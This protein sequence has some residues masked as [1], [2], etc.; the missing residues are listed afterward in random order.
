[1]SGMGMSV[2]MGG[3]GSAGAGVGAGY[4]CSWHRS[5]R[6]G[7]SYADS[8]K[9]KS[10]LVVPVTTPTYKERTPYPAFAGPGPQPHE[11][12]DQ[13]GGVYS[14]YGTDVAQEVKKPICWK[15]LGWVF[16]LLVL[17]LVLGGSR[18]RA[19]IYQLTTIGTNP[20]YGRG[21]T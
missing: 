5:C 4:H 14:G 6:W 9:S 17:G 8:P 1:M 16:L 15:R 11:M 21:E 2:G 13:C 18:S 7:C 19:C 10:T 3:G 12:Y 20:P